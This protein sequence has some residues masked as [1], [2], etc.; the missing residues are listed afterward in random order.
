MERPASTRLRRT[1]T[2]LAVLLGGGVLIAP[3]FPVA[4][5]YWHL[6][7][8][9]S[10]E[11][12]QR[13]S[14][15]H[16]LA[17]MGSPKAVPYLLELFPD[18]EVGPIGSNYAGQALRE[19]GQP[20]LPK[21]LSAIKGVRIVFCWK[22]LRRPTLDSYRF[23]ASQEIARRTSDALP[24]VPGL[25]EMLKSNDSDHVHIAALTLGDLAWRAANAEDETQALS[26]ALRA[27]TPSLV[28]AL[29]HGS[30]TVRRGVTYSLTC[31]GEKA[32]DAVPA[33]VRSL[34]DTDIH[35]RQN[36]AEALGNVPAARSRTISALRPLL[37]DEAELVRLAA[38]YSLFRLGD[39]VELSLPVLTALLRSES[40]VTQRRAL[41]ALGE[42]GEK[43]R[44]AIDSILPFTKDSSEVI[45]QEAI[46]TL[47]KIAPPE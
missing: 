32:R 2:T 43:G 13:K 37:R 16:V 29:E 35:V 15:A 6:R 34:Q 12:E 23:S 25:V 30:L 28:G 31:F 27:A 1:V 8:L 5:E 45:R 21:L 24:V 42:L 46:R 47:A 44:P 10:P 4:R 26:E 18:V 3:L 19:I 39:D 11:R 33:L 7:R 22:D 38:A 14:A 17:Q 40:S 20:A 9:C 36:A 41:A